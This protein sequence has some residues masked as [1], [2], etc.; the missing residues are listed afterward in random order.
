MLS[1][2]REYKGKKDPYGIPQSGTL[3]RA[4]MRPSKVLAVHHHDGAGWDAIS[5]VLYTFHF[6]SLS[7]VDLRLSPLLPFLSIS[8][9]T[10]GSDCVSV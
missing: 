2:T 4:E 7:E 3:G 1:G 5:K 10:H 9:S 8:F 6:K